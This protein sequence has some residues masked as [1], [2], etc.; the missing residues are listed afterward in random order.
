MKRKYAAVLIASLMVSACGNTVYGPKRL[1]QAG[2][3]DGRPTP[4]GLTGNCPISGPP[5]TNDQSLDL[6]KHFFNTACASFRDAND[7]VKARRMMNAGVTLTMTR[8]ND[9]FAQRAGNQT[10]ARVLREAIP[11]VSALLT[12]IIGLANFDTDEGRQEAIQILGLGQTATVAGL[13]VFQRE[14]LF[15]S[16]N[17][18][19][20][21]NLTMRALDEHSSQILDSDSGFY[22]ATRHL[23]E[24]QMICT[25]ASILELVTQAIDDGDI[26]SYTQRVEQERARE[27][28]RD[29]LRIRVI[30]NDLGAP[31]TLTSDEFGSLWTVFRARQSG[32]TLSETQMAE[33]K[34]RLERVE[35]NV[36]VGEPSQLTKRMT[37]NVLPELGQFS[38]ELERHFDT[39]ADNFSE[40]YSEDG[41]AAA[42]ESGESFAFNYPEGFAA[43]S[44]RRVEVGVGAASQ[45]GKK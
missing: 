37:S 24:H 19:S 39:Q 9:F 12:G 2:D 18:F 13:E 17:V 20:V 25:P 22:P 6:T 36:F 33:L 38:S 30:A 45:N 34:A 29:N 3:F 26:Q 16:Q 21:R 5:A 11:P 4:V 35:N 7:P 23:I 15:D 44:S 32:T 27:F 40:R 1:V 8:C 42:G 10:R 43:Q 31:T 14:F 28:E 41:I